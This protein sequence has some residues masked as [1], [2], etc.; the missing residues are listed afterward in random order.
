MKTI[1]LELSKRLAPY[2]EDV[3]T[4][5]WL[6]IYTS[7]WEDINE[8]PEDFWNLYPIWNTRAD[9]SVSYK[10]IKTLTLEEAIEFVRNKLKN[11]KYNLE[12]RLA[13]DGY[14]IELSYPFRIFIWE[15]LIEA[16]EKMLEYL[17]DN[18]LLW[19]DTKNL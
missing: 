13:S 17:L 1:T 5:Y 2:L 19:K 7:D 10:Q 8:A 6:E 12:I 3:D 16:T 14:L 4:E 11:T 18:E 15:K 9:T